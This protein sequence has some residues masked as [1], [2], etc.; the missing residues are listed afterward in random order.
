MDIIARNKPKE[1]KDLTDPT[2]PDPSRSRF[3]EPLKFLPVVFALG[4]TL[5]LW[6]IY[7]VLFCIPLL[8]HPQTSCKAKLLLA[9]F[10][11]LTFLLLVSYIRSMLQHP[12]TVPRKRVSND[13]TWEIV[14]IRPKASDAAYVKETKKSGEKR[15]CKWCS[16]QKPDRA[17]H[18]RVCNMCIL[19]M[20][21][22]CP[23]LYNCVGFKN[24]KYFFL[25]ILYSV[26]SL[27]MIF[28]TMLGAVLRI[29]DDASTPVLTM[30]AL[31]LGE[32]LSG[33]LGLLLTGFFGYHIFLSLGATTT[34]EFLEKQ[35]PRGD[36]RA[37]NYSRGVL[38]NIK[39]IL[40]DNVLLWLLPLSPP[41]GDGLSFAHV[42][43]EATPL[44]YEQGHEKRRKAH[45]GL[46]M[47]PDFPG[48]QPVSGG[49]PFLDDPGQ[50][51]AKGHEGAVETIIP[52]ADAG[53]G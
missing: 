24:Y 40:G 21:H 47:P 43:T 51:A 12:G 35:R 29:I 9:I 45:E 10:N 6:F 2:D 50:E 1:F 11:G 44:R 28:W 36:L 52:G 13:E 31:L 7:V 27:H 23:F 20:D 26:L 18:C 37:V 38:G 48:S 22:H 3:G 14:T 39:A 42:A 17:H 32:T 19:K 30:F 41:S 53:A 8:Q 4:I 15:T 34:I 16:H 46:L 49:D 33:F 25:L 5:G